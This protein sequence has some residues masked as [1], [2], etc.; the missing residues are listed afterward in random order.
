MELVVVR[1]GRTAW[2]AERRFQGHT[3]VPLDDEGRAQ[4]TALAALLAA[5]SF[6]SAVTSDL[7]RAQETARIVLGPRA[8]PLRVDPGW[9]EMRFGTWEGLT[10]PE[11]VAAHPELD[12]ANETAPRVYTPSGGESF[13][14]VCARIEGALE[15]V[16][17]DTPAG[18]RALIATHAGPLHAM[19]RVLL[20]G[21]GADALKVRFL[22]ASVSRFARVDGVWS[23]AAL[24]QTGYEAA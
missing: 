6:A 18:G 3:D 24:N 7:A 5:D 23:L 13:D 20:G 1:H 14:G 10:W 22:T 17:A 15:R 11:I 12:E 16:I 8:L 4:A 2:N 19:L 9:R 21:D